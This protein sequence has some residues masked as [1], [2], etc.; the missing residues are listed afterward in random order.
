MAAT[1]LVPDVTVT[2]AEPV[3]SQAPQW[4]LWQR[5]LFRFFFVYLLFQTEPWFLFNDIPGVPFLS[6]YYSQAMDWAVQQSNTRVFR[7]WDTLVQPNGSGDTSWAFTQMWM[8]LGV[9]AI[10][11]AVWSVVD[12]KRPSYDR[13]LYW[14]RTILRYYLASAALSYGIIK[15]FAL[16]MPFPSVSQLATPLGDLLPM[17][18][19]WL[20]IGYSVPYQ[21]F[22]GAMETLAGLLLLSR[23]TV[24][25]GL[26]AAMGAF[27][28]VVMINLSYDVPVKLFSSHLLFASVFLLALDYKRILGFMV[29]NRSVPATNAW[30]PRYAKPWHRWVALGV[31]LFIVWVILVQPLQNSWT[32]YKALKAPPVPGPFQVGF[33]D[34]RHYVV[35]HDTIP[36][37]S[38]DTLRWKDVIIDNLTAGSVNTH[39]GVFWQRYRRGYFRY[40]P[41]TTHRM[42]SVWK[43]S[44][45]PRDSTFLFTMRYEVPDSVTVRF[46]T[47]IRNDSVHVEMVRVPRHFQLSERQFHWL[48]EYN[49]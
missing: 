31:K 39:D 23:R 43:V 24:T 37:A 5:V 11:C 32:R 45:I 44:T 36:A 10:A 3:T 22:S 33:Y 14:L 40:K 42:L 8:L 29:L 6:R 20:F 41:D 28:N 7:V 47:M 13:A 38:A 1:A 16:Q 4:P 18:F 2:A 34:V 27:L 15:L 19:S 48:S 46:H 30:Q 35:N 12:R 9:A 26:F 21:F 49:R 17:R 25:A